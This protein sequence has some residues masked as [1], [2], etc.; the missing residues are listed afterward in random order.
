MVFT[1]A[2]STSNFLCDL[3]LTAT[4]LIDV[5]STLVE[6][7]DERLWTLTT[8]VFSFFLQSDGLNGEFLAYLPG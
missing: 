5:S 1:V 6:R 3:L 2:A 8:D 7:H 4:V